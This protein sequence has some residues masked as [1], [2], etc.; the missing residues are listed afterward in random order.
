MV[1]VLRVQSVQ[2]VLHALV[3]KVLRQHG[4]RILHGLE[5]EQ[6]LAGGKGAD[7]RAELLL[8]HGVRRN[9]EQSLDAGRLD[10]DDD[11][12]GLWLMMLTGGR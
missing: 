9:G 2:A 5:A 4:E 7:R 1:A 6:L 10:D 12:A 8:L 11:D 3:A